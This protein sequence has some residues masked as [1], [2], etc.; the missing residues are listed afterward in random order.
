MPENTLSD[1]KVQI[2]NPVTASAPNKRRVNAQPRGRLAES[3]GKDY[4][5]KGKSYTF[6]RRKYTKKARKEGGFRL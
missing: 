4:F 6:S 5:T 3:E 1:P 2:G